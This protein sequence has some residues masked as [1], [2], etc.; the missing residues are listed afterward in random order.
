[1]SDNG[2]EF[3]NF[4]LCSSLVFF[5]RLRVIHQNSHAKT[6]QQNRVVE[7]KYHN[8]LNIAYALRF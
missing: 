1:M 5:A 4:Q 6:S 3:F 8:L 7:K 2:L